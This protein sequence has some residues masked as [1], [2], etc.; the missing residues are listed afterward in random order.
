MPLGTF[1]WR[2][3][4]REACRVVLPAKPQQTA[5]TT[6]T[7]QIAQQTLQLMVPKI[8]NTFLNLMTVTLSSYAETEA[9]L[10]CTSTVTL[11]H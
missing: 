3:M 5:H 2:G 8:N 10:S 1:T 9:A 7:A 11:D 4:A 6:Q